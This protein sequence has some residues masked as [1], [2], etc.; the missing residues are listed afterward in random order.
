MRDFI[1]GKIRAGES[2][3]DF[4]DITL[5]ILTGDTPLGG[6][7]RGDKD[8]FM[9]KSVPYLE[10]YARLTEGRAIETVLELGIFKGGSVVFFDRF[11]QPKQLTAL[12]IETDR[13]AK[14]DTYVRDS[15]T[16]HIDLRYGVSQDD[17]PAIAAIVAEDF[18]TG[19]DFVV[20]D[21]SHFYSPTRA[22]FEVIFPKVRPGGTYVV[23]DWSWGHSNPWDGGDNEDITRMLHQLIV[24]HAKR[25]DI[26]SQIHLA[27]GFFAVTRGPTPLGDDFELP[28]GDG[29][30]PAEPAKWRGFRHFLGI[31]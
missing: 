7:V 13:I 18:P 16:A 17:R 27:P 6:F 22:S 11:F 12:D 26:I 20:D 4:G 24:L 5:S 28:Q 10:G 2:V 1:L 19:I 31:K 29:I 23:E 30:K 8:F 14:L 3:V 25:S 9:A 15:A 21:A